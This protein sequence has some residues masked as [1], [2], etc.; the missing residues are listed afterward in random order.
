V[1]DD[2]RLYRRVATEL[3]EQDGFHVSAA[4][5]GE[6][7]LSL[8]PTSR[9]DLV[10]LDMTMP[11]INGIETCR[12]LKEAPETRDVPVIF[13]SSINE[14]DEVVGGLEAGASDY[15]TKPFRPAELLARVRAHVRL[16]L[17][18]DERLSLYRQLE[19]EI[20]RAGQIQAELLDINPPVLP[21]VDLAAR[22][23]PAREVGGDFYSWRVT[24]PGTLAVTLGDVMGKGMPAALLM[25]TVRAAIRAVSAQHSPAETLA[26]AQGALQVDLEPSSS[27]VTLFHAQLDLDGGVLTYVDA[28]HGHL[29]VRR[30]DASLHQLQPRGLPL[31]ILPDQ[32]YEEGAFLLQPGDVMVA[33]SDGFLESLPGALSVPAYIST[34][35][36]ESRPAAKLVEELM[37]L[38]PSSDS[39][40]DD[41]TVLVLRYLGQ[42]SS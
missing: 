42:A 20:L 1:V 40:S 18:E 33:Y 35:V 34:M 41:A 19:A 6:E 24:R 30:R 11:G 23:I 12:R 39:S 8:A 13:F 9:P 16:K 2:T 29:F 7:A 3:L 22:C 5:C 36:D 27:F 25:A 17:L 37:A 10:L 15:I 21:G 32:Q 26:L 28:G 38:Q 4:S 14:V 31:G